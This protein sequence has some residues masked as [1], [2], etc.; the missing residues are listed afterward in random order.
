MPRTRENH[1]QHRKAKKSYTLSPES[2]EFLEAI[3]KKRRVTSISAV[4]EEILQNVRREHERASIE[5]AVAEYYASFSDQ[6]ASEQ[7]AW[8]DFAEQE[9][10]NEER[11]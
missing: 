2:V 10:P 1:S 11:G 5:R 4:L 7:A 3:R 6:D 9:F 8:G